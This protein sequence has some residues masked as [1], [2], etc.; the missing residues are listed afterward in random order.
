MA[1]PTAEG[2]NVDE[3]LEKMMKVYSYID[4]TGGDVQWLQNE[5]DDFE[6]DDDVVSAVDGIIEQ[7][8]ALF[9]TDEGEHIMDVLAGAMNSWGGGDKTDAILIL[10]NDVV[11][12][13]EKI[14]SL[15]RDIEDELQDVDGI[16]DTELWRAAEYVTEQYKFI[17][18][19]L[20]RIAN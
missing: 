17:H 18:T 7:T 11:P 9:T 16:E 20:N 4:S 13:F 12:V 2:R 3:T 19:T 8:N 14:L 10:K 6:G 5:L 15:H 1:H